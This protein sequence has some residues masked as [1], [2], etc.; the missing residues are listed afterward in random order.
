V[1]RTLSLAGLLLAALAAQA[2]AQKDK[3]VPTY[4][5]PQEVFDGVL[6]AIDAR[7]A[8]AMIGCF[9]P[10]AQRQMAA[11][12][13]AQGAFLRAQ[14]ESKSSKDK[15]EDFVKKYRPLFD[16]MDKHG[17]TAKASKGLKVKG[18]RPTKEERE[19]ILKLLDDPAAFAADYAAAYDKVEPRKDR[20]D[21]PKPK[22]ADVK[23][24]GDKAVANVVVTVARKEKDRELSREVKQPVSFRK[25][26]G[27]WRM[28]AEP[29]ASAR[30]KDG[31]KKDR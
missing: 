2:T 12:Y 28:E 24:D 31:P 4:K 19:A 5:T 18:L 13:A 11:R 6:A 16:V 1:T 22:L 15:D 17:L 7:D 20:K 27:G 10:Q 23:I 9:T 8:R 26:D 29:E 14:A 3:A 30:E 21:E 25:I